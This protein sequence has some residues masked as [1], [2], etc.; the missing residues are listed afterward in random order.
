MMH[1]SNPGVRR[2]RV[3]Q[4]SIHLPWSVYS[5][6][7]KTGALDLSRFSFGAK[8]SSLATST[9]PP[10]FSEAR[11]MSSVK[12]ICSLNQPFSTTIV[13]TIQALLSDRVR[14]V[15]LRSQGAPLRRHAHETYA[16]RQKS[17]NGQHD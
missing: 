11:S 15:R 4:P 5:P 3:S 13:L 9:A 2:R 1:Q 10:S 16:V 14:L 7:K 6:S 8:N 17:L 12:S